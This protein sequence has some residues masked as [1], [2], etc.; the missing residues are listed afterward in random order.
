MKNLIVIGAGG[1]GREVL[2]WAE[3]RKKVE[4]CWNIKGYLDDD[5]HALD[6][7]KSNYT[8]LGTVDQYEIQKEDVF[9]CAIGNPVIREKVVRKMQ[10]K[11]AE[12][13][14]VIHPTAVVA[15][16]ADIGTGS[17]LYPYSIVSDNAD[18]K[19]HCIVNMHS[20]VAHDAILGRYC[21]VSAFCDITGNT[22]LGEY[23]FLGSGVKIVPSTS[24]GNHAFVCAGSIVM[25]RVKDNT[26]VLGNPA[27]RINL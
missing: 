23:V 13:V 17:I 16:T 2:Q 15:D 5:L 12:F 7:K 4:D 8:V 20:C 3:D 18:I 25:T 11:G 21:T 27:K 9:V 24:V 19:E 22:R 1:C 14:S 6:N 10:E 26:K